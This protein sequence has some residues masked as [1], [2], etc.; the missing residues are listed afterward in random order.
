[1]RPVVKLAVNFP[2]RE[3]QVA[4]LHVLFYNFNLIIN[5]HSLITCTLC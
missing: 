4:V 3:Q 1:M 5:G 2:V